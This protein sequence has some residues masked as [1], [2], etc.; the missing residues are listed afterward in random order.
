MKSAV[1]YLYH[2]MGPHFF[3]PQF[4]VMISALLRRCLIIC[5]ILFLWLLAANNA[6]AQTPGFHILQG[7]KMAEIPFRKVNNLIVVPVLLNNIIPLQFILDTGVRTA[8]LTDR[9]YSDILDMPY[10]R[11]LSVK[12]AGALQQV[13]AYVASNISFLL[14]NVQA[15]GQALL[16]LEED[17]LELSKQLGIGVHGILGYEF[18]R[19]FLVKID[20]E[21]EVLTLYEPDRFK[22]SRRYTRLPLSIE[23][24]KPYITCSLQTVP[25][26]KKRSVKLLVDTGASH[27]LLL[28]QNDSA[29]R[30]KLPEKTIYGTLG[31]GIV[32]NIMGHIGRVSQ[33]SVEDFSFQN[34][35]TS[36]PDDSSYA[37]IADWSTR[38]G[39]IGGDLLNRFTVIFDY[40]HGFI[41]LLKNSDYSDP[42]V[43][44][45]TGMVIQAEAETLNSF[46]VMQVR[47]NTP[48]SEAGIQEGDI[49]LR[50]NG[51]KTKHMDLMKLNHKLRKRDGKK[52]RLKLKRGEEEFKTSFRLRNII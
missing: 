48:A 43:Y 31:R 38:E 40:P 1:F 17:Y 15:Q 4:P 45:K 46:T 24:S 10:D 5:L 14:P 3:R 28:H 11:K 16:I 29:K 2:F 44:S 37:N 7:K 33:F 42:F 20:Y 52:I 39:T 32:G 26:E 51:L 23:D 13:D 27:A 25:S 41:Y 8:I 19:K 34:V 6:C 36:F 35:L 30:F 22:V 21:K 18:F 12:G 50:I 49:L 9:L 47:E